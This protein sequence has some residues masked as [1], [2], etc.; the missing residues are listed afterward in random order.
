MI[1]IAHDNAIFGCQHDIRKMEVEGT[2]LGR[3][4]GVMDR[5]IE[6]ISPIIYQSTVYYSCFIQ[7]MYSSQIHSQERLIHDCGCQSAMW[8]ACEQI[9]YA[10]YRR[11]E[12][13]VQRRMP[14]QRKLDTSR[15][16]DVFNSCYLWISSSALVFLEKF[17]GCFGNSPRQLVSSAAQAVEMYNCVPVAGVNL[18][19]PQAPDPRRPSTNNIPQD[20]KFTAVLKDLGVCRSKV[21]QQ[22]G[23][24]FTRRFHPPVI[25]L[26]STADNRPTVEVARNTER[27][28]AIGILSCHSSVTGIGN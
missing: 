6:K 11:T 28:S 10:W 3:L 8:P 25:H 20:P 27:P 2:A 14:Q 13:Q 5:S 23:P 19:Q 1:G 7:K 18:L 9:Q 16:F 12:K 4:R 22:A 17:E 26:L 21:F 15:C 24:S